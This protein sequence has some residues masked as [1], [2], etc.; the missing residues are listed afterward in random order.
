M[1][2]SVCDVDRIDDADDRGV[3]GTVFQAGCHAG[4]A[5]AD[6]QDGF[7]DA[8]VDRVDRDELRAFRLAARIHG[9]GNEQLV[10]DEPRV[11]SRRH[12]RSDDFC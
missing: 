4:G 10:T 8:G 3:D 2:T 9:T 11:F 12:N 7:A 5:A 1:A 6:D